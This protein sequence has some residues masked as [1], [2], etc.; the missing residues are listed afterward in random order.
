MKN[1][2]TNPERKLAGTEIC[3]R[4]YATYCFLEKGAAIIDL[5]SWVFEK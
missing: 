4:M 3:T 5:K 2:A 1:H